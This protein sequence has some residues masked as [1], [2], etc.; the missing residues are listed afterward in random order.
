MI[1]MIVF[2]ILETHAQTTIWMENFDGNSGT[3]SNWGLLN[4]NIGVQGSAE[5][6]WY[7]SDTENGNASGVCGSAGGGD[8]TL[9]LGSTVAG[10]IGAA[11]EVGC[12]PGCFF[13]DV[14]GVCI[15]STTDKRSQSQDIST[16]GHN[17]LSLN[18]NYIEGGDLLI[19]DCIVE[20]SVDGGVSWNTLTNPPKTDAITCAPQGT[21]TSFSIALPVTCENIPNLRLAF[22]W[23]NNADG[24]GVDPSFAV[25]DI[26]IT[27]PTILPVH[28]V[29]FKGKRAAQVNRLDWTTSTEI[30]NSHFVLERS[31]DALLF[32]PL[33]E[34]IAKGNGKQPTTYSFEDKSAWVG[35]NYYRLKIVATNKTFH[36]SGLIHLN[37]EIRQAQKL[38]VFPNPVRESLRFNFLAKE[39]KS[40]KV[41]VLDVLGQVIEESIISIE[42][43][44]N[45]IELNSKAYEAGT[46]CLRVSDGQLVHNQLFIKQ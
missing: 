38:L 25:D 44:S 2:C 14:F 34:I 41:C 15:N 40:I 9:H 22:K 8:Q 20:F 39:H 24:V 10:D 23:T 13:C 26:T 12:S 30:D 33:G 27:K 46:Y 6:Q 43:G 5:N 1:F 18:F 7:I 31:K 16:I 32:E 19:D 42:A 17:N 29:D 11:Y 45:L 36:Y 4:E 35:H 37:S 28:L 21:W 3:G